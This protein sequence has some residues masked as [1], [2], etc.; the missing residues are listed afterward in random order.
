MIEN[1]IIYKT[2]DEALNLLAHLVAL[3][4]VPH[5]DHGLHKDRKLDNLNSGAVV[6]HLDHGL[7]NDTKLDNLSS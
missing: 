2:A 5:L 6:P 1:W 3:L 4:V 7:H